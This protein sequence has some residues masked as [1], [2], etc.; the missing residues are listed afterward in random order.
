MLAARQPVA[1]GITAIAGLAESMSRGEAAS[2]PVRIGWLA[3]M[4]LAA[5]TVARAA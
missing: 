1:A 5:L 3:A 4:W 2:R